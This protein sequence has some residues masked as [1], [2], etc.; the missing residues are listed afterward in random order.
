MQRILNL[1]VVSLLCVPAT[2]ADEYIGNYSAN[3]Y[4][5]N[6]ASNPY[7]EGMEIYGQ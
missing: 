2:W 7:G 1:V 5:Q 3:Q 4:N 6:S